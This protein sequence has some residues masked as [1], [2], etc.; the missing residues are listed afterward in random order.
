MKKIKTEQSM[1]EN[2][3]SSFIVKQIEL[4]KTEKT[5]YSVHEYFNGGSLSSYLERSGGRVSENVAKQ[6]IM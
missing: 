4:V 3:T 6:V 1:L 5:I 2:M